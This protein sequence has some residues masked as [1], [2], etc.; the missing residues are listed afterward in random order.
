MDGSYQLSKKVSQSLPGHQVVAV[1]KLCE[2]GWLYRQLHQYTE[3]AGQETGAGLVSQSF[4]T[5]VRA[6]LTEFY[7][8]LAGLEQN[9]RE[10]GVRLL[11]L[12]AWTRQPQARLR[13]LVEV[14]TSVGLCDPPP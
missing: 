11:Q 13:L 12:Q 9:L 5:A 4:V 2:V 14:V 10:G 3:A 6:E 7:R 8:L 1:S